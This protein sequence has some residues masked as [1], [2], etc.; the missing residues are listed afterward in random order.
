MCFIDTVRVLEFDYDMDTFEDILYCSKLEKLV[1][2]K[3]RYLHPTYVTSED[4]SI[5]YNEDKSAKV[6]ETAHTLRNVEIIQYNDHYF[7]ELFDFLT[8]IEK[9]G[10]PDI[11][12]LPTSCIDTIENSVKEVIGH[13]SHLSYLIHN[14]PPTYWEPLESGSVRNY[15]L[16]ITLKE[17]ELVNGIKVVQATYDP[18]LD[19]RSKNY[20]P[21]EIKIQVSNDR[22]V[23]ENACYT[24]E[25]PLGGG[26]GEVTL[27]PLSSP[28]EVKYIKINLSDRVYVNVCNIKLA[29]IALY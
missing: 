13:D 26:S 9:R 22:I 29:D 20:L 17:K 16:I 4:K 28:K 27:L 8:P 10:F 21:H 12:C 18:A 15:E 1:L 19:S 24:L 23:W 14:N 3:N 2:G 5:L 25:N 11:E 6:L 7:T